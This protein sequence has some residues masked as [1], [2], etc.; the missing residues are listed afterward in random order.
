MSDAER[1]QRAIESLEQMIGFI[2]S[3]D[4]IDNYHDALLKGQCW[5]DDA[6]A[7]D[8]M[9]TWLILKGMK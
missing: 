8:A 1:I 6:Y 5:Y 3:A 2:P 4:D 9:R 7:N